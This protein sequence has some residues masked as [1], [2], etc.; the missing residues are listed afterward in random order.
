MWE[1][2]SPEPNFLF[3]LQKEHS[4]KECTPRGVLGSEYCYIHTHTL[5]HMACD[6]PNRGCI[7][8]VRVPYLGLRQSRMEE[9]G[10]R[11]WGPSGWPLPGMTAVGIAR[12]SQGTKRTGR[13][14][15]MRAARA[16]LGSRL[17][18]VLTSLGRP[19]FKNRN[20]RMKSLAS[21]GHIQCRLLTCHCY[22]DKRN[23][24]NKAAQPALCDP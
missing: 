13:G 2:S 12:E 11:A 18:L 6:H 16:L 19:F 17:T 3:F 5:P 8:H 1:E 10:H 24:I 23:V 22:E 15:K 9:G 14:S 7:T 20:K 4:G 21:I